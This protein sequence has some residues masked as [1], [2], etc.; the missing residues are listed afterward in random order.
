[1]IWLQLVL[2]AVCAVGVVLVAVA[3]A[4]DVRTPNAVTLV[5]GLV[6]VG[7]VVQL[8]LGLVRV[9]GDHAGV[10]VVVYLAYLI[11]SLVVL[12]LAWLWS[13]SDGS[14]GG[15]AVLLVAFVVVPVLFLRLNQIWSAHGHP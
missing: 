11:G 3:V 1:M 2:T 5:A 13:A 12:P 10:N 6:E 14:R 15:T 7:L 8:V 9:L 4:R